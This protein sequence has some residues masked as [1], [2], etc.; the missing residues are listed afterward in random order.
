MPGQWCNLGTDNYFG[1][2]P[3]SKDGEFMHRETA[4][5]CGRPLLS[6]FD[7]NLQQVLFLA[8]SEW[9]RVLEGMSKFHTWKT[10]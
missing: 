6:C 2:L 7:Y 8:V 9:A 5:Q 1:L 4:A 10:L 3:N